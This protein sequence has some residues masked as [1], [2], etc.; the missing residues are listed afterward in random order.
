VY[1]V[2]MKPSTTARAKF[3][4]VND[5]DDARD[6]A[7]DYDADLDAQYEDYLAECQEEGITPLPR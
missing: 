5:P 2:R 4:Y 1:T 6:L 7:L 3:R